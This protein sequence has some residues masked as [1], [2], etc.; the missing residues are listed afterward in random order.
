MSALQ[1]FL[2]QN[3]QFPQVSLQILPIDNSRKP[4]EVSQFEE[5]SFQS[6]VIVPVDQFSLTLRNPTLEGSLLDFVRDGDIALL[7]AN[8]EVVATGLI[9]SV[10]VRTD[11][12]GEVVLVQGRTLIGQLEDQSCVN[13]QDQQIWFTNATIDQ[14]VRALVTRTRIGAYRIQQGP[15]APPL[16]LATEP[17]ENKMSALIRYLEPLNCLAWMDPDGTLVVGRPDMGSPPVGRLQMDRVNREANCISMQSIFAATQVPN[18]LIS[19]WAGQESVQSRVAASQ[20]LLNNA[21]GPSRLYGFKH[22]VPKTIVTSAPSGADPQSAATVANLVLSGGSTI[23]QAYAKRE[24]ARANVNEMQVQAVVKGHYR[25]DL[26]PILVDTC[27][28]VYYP[29]GGVDETL[30]LHTVGYS[31]SAREGQR[32]SLSLCRLGSIVADV[33]KLSVKSSSVR[34]LAQ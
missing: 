7:K 27:F 23:L 9:D 6:S 29:R 13:D 8:G 14:A 26:V 4:I 2:D 28:D 25:D 34:R 32:T 3:G 21:P 20:I 15:N 10:N 24:L 16:P 1:E 5:Y 22:R 30:Y 33:S 17:G 19:V 31:M 18:V 12:E 11:Q